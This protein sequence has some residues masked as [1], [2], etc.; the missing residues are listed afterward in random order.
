M[1]VFPKLETERLVL[2][3][4]TWH[5]REALFNLLARE[6]VARYMDTTPYTSVDQVGR[7]ITYLDGL[8]ERGEGLRWAITLRQGGKLAGTCGFNNWIRR[9]GSRGEIGYDLHPDYWGRGLMTEALR[10]VVKHGFTTMSLNRIEAL[11]NLDNDRS[12]RVLERLGFQREGLLREY[13]FWR[14]EYWDLY[15]YSL[16][17]KEWTGGETDI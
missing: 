13:G 14:G 11:V 12:I 2:R 8:W 16:L 1:I 7:L 4:L 15:C 17:R 10:A 5:D 6:E 3:R 9:R